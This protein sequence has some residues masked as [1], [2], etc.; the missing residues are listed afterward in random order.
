MTKKP[1][2]KSKTDYEH[3]GK[4]LSEIYESGYIDHHRAYKTSFIKGMMSGLGG[5]IGATIVL[6]LLLWLLSL[7]QEI[8]LV[9][10]FLDSVQDT[11]KSA[12][13]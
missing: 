5:V 1:Q 12:K 9:G 10:P 3:L 4:M 11:L 8:P 6:A 7:F 2:S 13:N